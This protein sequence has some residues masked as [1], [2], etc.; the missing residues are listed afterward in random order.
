M[1]FRQPV[2]I[3]AGQKAIPHTCGVEP[4]TLTRFVE[5][6]NERSGEKWEYTAPDN[7]D[8]SGQIRLANET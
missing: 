8:I 7:E 1:Y 4:N 5:Y 3:T 2:G 6:I